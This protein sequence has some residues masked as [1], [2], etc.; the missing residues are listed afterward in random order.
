MD[1][2]RNSHLDSGR[3]MSRGGQTVGRQ[4]GRA[5]LDD[6]RIGADRTALILERQSEIER[7]LDR[8]DSYVCDTFSQGEL[9]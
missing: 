9:V 3:R 8:H 1:S 6:E 2:V 5:G 7:V 4:G